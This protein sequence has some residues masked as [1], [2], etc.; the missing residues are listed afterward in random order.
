MK[1]INQISTL[2]IIAIISAL[3][4]SCSKERIEPDK[5]SYADLS[6]YLDSHKRIEEEFIITGPSQDTI[7]GQLGTR[8]YGS[9][10][11]LRFQN[12]DTVGYPFTIK[13]IELYTPDQM[14]YY[15]MSSIA[16]GDVMDTEGIIKITAYKDSEELVLSPSCPVGFEM[17]N[18]S[19]TSNKSI[20]IG[21]PS[22]TDTSVAASATSY[23]YLG[24]TNTL[25]WDNCANAVNSTG[26]HTL[27]FSSETDELGNVGIF[28]YFPATGAIMEVN[29]LATSGIPDGQQ[30]E[31]ICLAIN[32]ANSMYWYT[33]TRTVTAS[34]TIDIELVATTDGAI[35]SYLGGL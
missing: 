29:S 18:D 1:R 20:F 16:S 32:S 6:P 30:V 15:Q 31:I 17:P 24:Y 4:F 12:G 14:I 7:I 22:W 35:T 2:L 26:G 13:L 27:S 21:G 9:K 19:P 25:G 8:I 10:D 34:A 3:T 11:C 28:L 5:N 33:E 23:G